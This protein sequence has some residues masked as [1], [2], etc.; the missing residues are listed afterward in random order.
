ME[1]KFNTSWKKGLTLKT[2]HVTLRTNG[3][4][5]EKRRT[6]ALLHLG[7]PMA[8]NEQHRGAYLHKAVQ[9][10]IILHTVAEVE[11][12]SEF[13]LYKSHEFQGVF[14]ELFWIG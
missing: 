7:E 8:H 6:C 3:G 14:Y 4:D 5:P 9:Y 1:K 2:F 12:E 11:R 10:N 13:L